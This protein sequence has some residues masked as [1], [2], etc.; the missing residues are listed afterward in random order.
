MSISRLL[1][2]DRIELHNSAGINNVIYNIYPEKRIFDYNG[3]NMTIKNIEISNNAIEFVVLLEDKSSEY[4]NIV[5]LYVVI[6]DNIEPFAKKYGITYGGSIYVG[7]NVNVR[8]L[9]KCVYVA[10]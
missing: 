6:E 4:E 7:K 9:K 8:R 10:Q 2:L 1:D 5:Y 3:N